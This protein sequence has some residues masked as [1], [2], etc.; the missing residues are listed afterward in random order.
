MTTSGQ[1]TTPRV[2]KAE[3][4]TYISTNSDLNTPQISKE[5]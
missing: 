1:A 4:P 3:E 2:N 5:K